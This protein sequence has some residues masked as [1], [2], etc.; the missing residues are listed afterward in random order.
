MQKVVLMGNIGNDAEIKN[1]SNKQFV[2]FNL[3]VTTRRKNGDAVHEVTNWYD[4]AFDNVKLAQHLTK[5]TKIYVEGNFKIDNYYSEKS[6]QW[7]AKMNVF[8]NMLE[9]AGGAKKDDSG[10]TPTKPQTPVQA[11]EQQSNDKDD[12]PF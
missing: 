7:V 1:S 4:C 6:G 9:F 11:S 5:G 8:V 2:T 3:A 10:T 12:L